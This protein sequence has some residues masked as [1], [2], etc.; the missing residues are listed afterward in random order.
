MANNYSTLRQSPDHRCQ[1][2]VRPMSVPRRGTVFLALDDVDLRRETVGAL[3]LAGIDV[4]EVAGLGVLCARL[5]GAPL[6][7]PSPDVLVWDADIATLS[8]L[9]AVWHRY[10]EG[11]TPALVLVGEAT[12]AN[13]SIESC[14]PTP[15]SI[16]AAVELALCPPARSSGTQ[17]RPVTDR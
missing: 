8:E 3:W 1:R 12:P 11:P 10:G 9:D 6:L 16:L 14:A 7:G 2:L 17:R 5:V 13:G 4:E 15:D